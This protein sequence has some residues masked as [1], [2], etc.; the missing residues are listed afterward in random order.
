M[1][2]FGVVDLC[3]G[4]GGL[5]YA[6]RKAG[7]SVWAGVDTSKDA[8]NS[9]KHNFPHAEAIQGSIADLNIIEQYHQTLKSKKRKNQGLVIV[10]GPPCQGF[11]EAG[12][13]CAE[14]PRN[15]ILV[16]VAKT[17]VHLKPEAGLVENVPALQKDKYSPFVRRFR[18]ILNNGG[19]HIYSFELNALEFGVPQKRRRMLYYVLPFS[20]QKSRILDDFKTFHR[21]AKTVKD[22]LG[23]LPVP[24]VRP[25]D[26][27]PAKNNGTIANH[28]AMRH[29]KKV[30]TKIAAIEPGSGP[31]SYRKL[32]PESHAAT[33]LSGHR[34]PPAH[35]KQPRSITV[36]EALR[37]QGFPDSFRVM[38]TFS[39][40][41]G[42]V[43]N[44]V[45]APLGKAAL[46]VML[47]LLG[48]KL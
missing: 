48:E 23:D 17:I 16:S 19:Y 13:R 47:T 15:E 37:L 42:Q 31:L 5:S 45:P 39:N 10:S 6:A 20:I 29:S 41:M 25:L 46:S 12:P 11:S 27:D 21:T 24:P 14:D 35:Y 1:D 7:L 44:A 28:Y 30:R 22:I 26:Y 43:T 8:L 34:A 4:M 18:A 33:L 40:Q 3:C 2:R 36:R 38:G 9:Y 32:D